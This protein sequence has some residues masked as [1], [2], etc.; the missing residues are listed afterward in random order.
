MVSKDIKSY[1]NSYKW[2]VKQYYASISNRSCLVKKCGFE[3]KYFT[4]KAVNLT[5]TKKQN[6]RIFCGGQW[7]E[8]VSEWIQTGIKHLPHFCT[9]IWDSVVASEEKTTQQEFFKYYFI[10]LS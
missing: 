8:K 7:A 5:S 10:A 6:C 2:L 4:G 1:I 9:F 3:K